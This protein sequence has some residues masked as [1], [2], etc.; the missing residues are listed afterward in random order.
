MDEY[1]KKS[2][3]SHIKQYESKGNFERNFSKLQV[4][5]VDTQN[6]CVSCTIPVDTHLV[7]T[8]GTLHG[9]AAAALFDVVTSFAGIIADKERR[10][11]VTLTLSTNYAK[12]AVAGSTI[13][14][15]GKCMSVGKNLA[16]LEGSIFN[17][18]GSKLMTASHVKFV[19][20]QPEARL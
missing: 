8:Y 10:A 6:N 1:A 12:P 7:N 19:G 9:G 20:S 11:G 15:E 2:I 14:I 13:T 4:N 17:E 5:K 16:Y 18:A 3:N